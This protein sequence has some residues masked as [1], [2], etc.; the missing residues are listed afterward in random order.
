MSTSG[1]IGV[2]LDGT[3]AL[4]KGWSGGTIGEPVPL[5]AARVKDW[6]ERKMTDVDERLVG[7]AGQLTMEA[8][9]RNSLLPTCGCRSIWRW[10]K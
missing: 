1:W 7:S 2:D 8:E 10:I 3:L 6:L 5:M 4:Y 9:P